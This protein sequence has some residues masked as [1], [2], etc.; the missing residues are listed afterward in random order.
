[1]G[2]FNK[3]INEGRIILTFDLDFGEI[4]SLASG[5]AA[6]VV[7][8]RLNNTTPPFLIARL[9]ATLAEASE[10][11]IAGAIVVVEDA[12]LRIRRIPPTE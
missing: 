11:L 2:V 6:S 7:L 5:R 3:A 9:Q 10:A 8:F 4:L 1:L 12:R